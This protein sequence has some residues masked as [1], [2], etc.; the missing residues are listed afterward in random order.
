MAK[1]QPTKLEQ[2]RVAVLDALYN[3]PKNPKHLHTECK[4]TTR[5]LFA[6]RKAGTILLTEEGLYEITDDGRALVRIARKAQ[7]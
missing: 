7:K 6:M 4:A 1:K 2:V 3:G 5:D